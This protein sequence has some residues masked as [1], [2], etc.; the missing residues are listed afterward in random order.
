MMSMDRPKHARASYEAE[1]EPHA[2]D[3]P[4][5]VS[6]AGSTS[7]RIHD[8][9]VHLDL[10][11]IDSRV[12]SGR[13][14]LD[15]DSAF[16][17]E[18]FLDQSGHVDYELVN[19]ERLADGSDAALNAPG[20]RINGEFVLG[21]VPKRR[22]PLR[23]AVLVVCSI[24]VV[25]IVAVGAAAAVYLGKLDEALM[26]DDPD[27]KI[28]KAL[29]EPVSGE[30]YY[31]LLIGSDGREGVEGS[32]ALWAGHDGT[33]E[34]E[35]SDVM[36]LARIDEQNR[37]VTLLSVP[38]DTAWQFEDGRWG[39]LNY[40]YNFGGVPDCVAAV[41]QLS[42]V[43]ISHFVEIHMSGL[44]DL[45]DYLGGVTV[46]V[47]MPIDYHEALTFTDVHL[48]P[49]V[50][51]LSGAEAEV[52]AR[53]RVAYRGLY[54]YPEMHRQSVVRTIIEAIM[55]EILN[56]PLSELPET[57]LESA[58]CVNTDYKA[59]ELLSTLL[60]LG[61]DFTIYQGSAP[62]DTQLNASAGQ[63]YLTYLNPDGWARVMAVVE[64][65]GDPSTITYENDEVSIAG[66]DEDSQTSE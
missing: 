39:K 44:I 41:E 53:E 7:Q 35:R 5:G 13:D 56:R 37:Q 55:S 17:Y 6:L 4:G 64:S 66:E 49:G 8:G 29:T 54:D 20:M 51:V 9:G 57:L 26:L 61:R 1:R 60:H 34:D 32:D 42:G 46:D 19:A 38:R 52:Y 15:A 65:G 33:A 48:D 27:G 25:A 30:P 43:S 10:P 24:I 3:V 45:I 40:T 14:S 22:H 21:K 11:D 59:V 62:Y 36:I 16:G 47:E 12:G 23:T 2:A 28:E 18:R 63:Q 50:Q 31:V 58:R